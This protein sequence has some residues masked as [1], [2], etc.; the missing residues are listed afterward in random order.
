M[1]APSSKVS[2]FAAPIA[3]ATSLALSATARAASLCG[4][5]TFAPRKPD[6]GSARTVSSNRG[7]GT[8]RCW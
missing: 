8:G 4:I 3:R 1:I 2:V 5:V 6:P 7:G